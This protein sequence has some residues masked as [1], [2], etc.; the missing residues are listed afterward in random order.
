M[1]CLSMILTT[2][3]KLGGNS[4]FNSEGPGSSST[5]SSGTASK[6]LF[7]VDDPSCNVLKILYTFCI[8]GGNEAV[9]TVFYGGVL[10]SPIG[11]Q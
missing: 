7:C 11:V 10:I 1:T 5:A 8:W 9:K 2:W 4:G 3:V 6:E